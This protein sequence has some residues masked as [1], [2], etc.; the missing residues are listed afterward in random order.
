MKNNTLFK[1]ENQPD[2]VLLNSKGSAS[3]IAL[4]VSLCASQDIK[5]QFFNSGEVNVKDNTIMSV[6]MNYINATSGNFINDGNVYIFQNWK[7]DGTVSYNV[8]SA[9]TTLFRGT[10]QQLIEGEGK[11]TS[12]LQNVIFENLSDLVPFDLKTI[13]AVGNNSNFKNGIINAR[14]NDAKMIFNETASHSNATDL[15]FVDGKVQKNGKA[16]FEFPVGNDLFY[17]PTFHEAGSSEANIH[18]TEYFHENSDPKYPHN[19]KQKGILFINDKEYWKVTKD[20]DGNEKIVLSLSLDEEGGATPSQFFNL[21][22]NTQVAIVRWDETNGEWVN[23]KGVLGSEI[24]G[25]PYSYLLMGQVSGYGI[26]TMAIVEEEIEIYDIEVFNAMS[27]NDDGI[28]DTFRIKGIDQFPDNEVE[29]FNRWGVKVYTA[30]S[31]NESDN[32][33]R[34]YS[35]GRA[36]FNRGDKLPTGTYFYTIKYTTK[37]GKGKQKS[38]Y[39]Y[40]NNQ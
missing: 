15:S 23:E 2:S 27:P 19:K 7:N 25:Q 21:S 22:P 17:R 33:F 36:T 12:N 5:A 3:V 39:L 13:I 24:Y 40:I 6:D 31:Y 26:F 8:P 35:D 29:I 37:E 1:I 34:G 9:G 20:D 4:M 16:A 18:T 28:N 30:K 14:Y 11:K 32:V 10:Q 38:G